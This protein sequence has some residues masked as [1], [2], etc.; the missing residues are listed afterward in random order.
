MY[1]AVAFVGWTAYARL[2]RSEM[3]IAK[4][5]DYANAARV[6]GYT[7][8]RIMFRHLLPNVAGQ[9]LVFASSDFVLDIILGSSLGFFGLGARTPAPEWGLMI[10]EGRNFITAA[11]W[12]TLFPGLAIVL[13]GF[14]FS[15]LG[16]GLADFLRVE[17]R[18]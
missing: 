2:V 14:A 9:A 18:T 17:E 16:D 12:I 4:Q 6:L 7:D 10:A 8:A 15:L 11:P 3:L 5:L 1:I 13:V